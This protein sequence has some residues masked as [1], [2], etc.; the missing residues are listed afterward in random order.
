MK[1][2]TSELSRETRAKIAQSLPDAIETALNSY[3]QF[4]ARGEKDS[5]ESNQFKNHHNACKAALSHIELLIKLARLVD[6]LDDNQQDDLTVMIQ[7]AY[8]ELGQS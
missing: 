4:N 1:Q 3:R 2:K 6:V 7:N 8:D 5:E